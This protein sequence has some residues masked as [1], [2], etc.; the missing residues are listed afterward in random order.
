MTTSYQT[1]LEL[2]YKKTA[3]ITVMNLTGKIKKQVEISTDTVKWRS[4]FLLCR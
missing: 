3:Y 4:S 2:I 1:I